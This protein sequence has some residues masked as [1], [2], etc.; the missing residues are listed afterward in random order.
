MSEESKNLSYD[1]LSEEINISEN[2]NK[3]INSNSE[4]ILPE[5][6]ILNIATDKNLINWKSFLYELIYKEGLDPWDID[7]TV[8]TKK[9]LEALKDIKKLDFNISGKFLTIA[10]YLLKTKSEDFLEKDIRGFENELKNSLEEEGDFELE[11]NLLEEIENEEIENFDEKKKKYSLKIRNPIARKRKVNIFDLI[12]VLEKTLEQSQKRR[13]NY[14][15]RKSSSDV[16]YKGPIYKKKDKDLKQIIEEL[17]EEISNKI[18]ENNSHIL[19]N[20]LID[21][22]EYKIEVIEKFVPL[23]HLHNDSK[24][25]IIQ[26][27]HFGDIKIK[28]NN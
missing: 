22:A 6:K 26:E 17:F 1:E 7:L 9:Y 14:L 8:L 21:D 11:D 2:L 27:K 12:K 20:D 4:Y 3:N 24:I 25:Q 23:I 19:F 16:K 5:D 15:A 18:K 28:K 13:I 10:V